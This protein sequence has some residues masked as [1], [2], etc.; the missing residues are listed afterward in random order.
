MDH[1]GARVNGCMMP[2]MTMAQDDIKSPQHVKQETR[3]FHPSFPSPS[4]FGQAPLTPESGFYDDY[5]APSGAYSNPTTTSPSNQ[6]LMPM[7]RLVEQ[8][9]SFR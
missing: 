9:Y 3:L 4:E 2:Y 7:Q 8:Y 1:D 5:Y 6:L